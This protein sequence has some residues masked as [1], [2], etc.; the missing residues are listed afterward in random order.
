MPHDSGFPPWASSP[1]PTFKDS[2]GPMSLGL[3]QARLPLGLQSSLAGPGKCDVWLGYM[4]CL[5]GLVMGEG[6]MLTDILENT[7]IAAPPSAVL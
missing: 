4:G 3:F 7:G 6:S 2:A 5:R 1:T